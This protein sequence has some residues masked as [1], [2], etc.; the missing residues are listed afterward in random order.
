MISSVFRNYGFL[1][2]FVT[3]I[4]SP[5]CNLHAQNDRSA[6]I[7]NRLPQLLPS[8]LIGDAA[9]RKTRSYRDH[10]ISNLLLGIY[11]EYQQ[12]PNQSMWK[13]HAM[14]RGYYEKL[15]MVEEKVVVEAVAKQNVHTLKTVL[16]NMGMERISIFGNMISGIF[17]ISSIDKLKDLEQLRFVRPS[18]RPK[19]AKP[20]VSQGDFA[21][22]SDIARITCGLDGSNTTVGILSDSYDVLGRENDGIFSGELPGPENPFGYTS[23]VLKLA[24]TPSDFL[25][26]DE[27]RAMAEIIHDV[28]PGAKMAFHTAWLGL[29]DFA[30]GILRLADEAEADVIVDD[31]GY[32]NEPF[33]QDGIV[34]QAVN[35]VAA[36]GV[37]YVSSAGND[38]RQS[39][40]S[41]FRPLPEIQKL[42]ESDGYPIGD[43]VL[44]DFDPGPGVDAFQ[45][46]TIPYEANLFFQWSTPFASICPQSPGAESDLDIFL[47]A[48]EGDFSSA[49]FG[50]F[51]SNIGADPLEVIQ[52]GTD[53]WVDVYVVIGKY[54]G[55]PEKGIEVPGAN[56][57]PQRIKYVY[58]EENLF[59]EYKSHSS[60][61][62][63]HPNAAGAIAVGAV[64]YRLTPDYGAEEPILEAFS[65]SG[66]TP[67]FYSPCG[68][69]I[70][71][72][73]RNKPEV[74]AP[75]GVNTSF[76]G[77]DVE[78]DGHPNFFGTSAAAPHV[79]G[80]A[81]LMAQASPG[82]SPAEVKNILQ[83]TAIDMDDP[84]SADPDPG[85]DFGTGYGF[86]Q[87]AVALSEL[88]QCVGVARFEL[89]N[90]ET[91][92][93]I[94]ILEDG[95]RLMLDDL[96]TK[97]LAIKAI[98]EPEVVGSVKMALI[99]GINQQTIENY[100]PYS[101]FG[102]QSGPDG[103]TILTGQPFVFDVFDGQNYHIE[104][105]AYS[106]MNG[107]GTRLSSYNLS[108]S[109]IEAPLVSFSLINSK[110]DQEIFEFDF[111]D[112]WHFDLNETG[113]YLNIRANTVDDAKVGSIFFL[114][115]E[116]DPVVPLA[117]AKSQTEDYPPFALFGNDGHDYK[118]GSFKEGYYRI[119]ATPYS[120]KQLKGIAGPPLVFDF[121]VGNTVIFDAEE[122]NNP[123]ANYK[124]NVFPNPITNSHNIL[125]VK[126]RNQKPA[127]NT[128]T[129]VTYRIINHVGKEIYVH[130]K[131]MADSGDLHQIDVR[132]LRLNPGFY[133]LKVERPDKSPKITRL[134]KN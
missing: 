132:N 13:N 84:F 106:G 46:I 90:A 79:A 7:T 88:T 59:E 124:V 122:A 51:E 100:A 73:L 38:A 14:K 55:T 67:I 76:F 29:A 11:Q 35:Q 80:I 45:K 127:L 18:Y 61:I 22:A 72:E 105:H 118:D 89:Y 47:F 97:Q 101:L 109:L 126:L 82:L 103:T 34:A 74:C 24:D 133:Y 5:F 111:Y 92:Q 25:T 10:K 66:G 94:K 41:E 49:I 48:R 6:D 70:E 117:I 104:A 62:F 77:F 64:D 107:Q 125:Q 120:K 56:P 52:V 98:T 99:G 128:S 121:A 83:E 4:F 8:E 31:I 57:D 91:N 60:T 16:Q 39:Y 95:D 30:N 86:V 58:F 12:L 27:G 71:P 33:F 110:T 2:L 37:S 44:H 40:E 53:F 43:Y 119:T 87:A 68:E 20:V 69:P 65:S 81:S 123:I 75:D 129:E 112:N 9:A 108:F 21:Q 15:L 130:S 134:L 63:G 115:E 85:F 3:L 54:V 17:P 23:P 116:T 28:A 42:T 102:D 96:G 113:N 36:K 50:S 1:T 78:G 26:Q 32:Y 19:M 114:L 93:R 131:R